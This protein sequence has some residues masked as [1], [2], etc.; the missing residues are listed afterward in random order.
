MYVPAASLGDG[1]YNGEGMTERGKSR[2]GVSLF[3]LPLIGYQR[4]LQLQLQWTVAI[5]SPF[6]SINTIFFSYNVILILARWGIKKEY[7]V[8]GWGRKGL[9]RVY[10]A[11]QGNK[12]WLA[13][14]ELPKQMRSVIPERHED[15]GVFL[16]KSENQLCNQSRQLLEKCKSIYRRRVARKEIWRERTE[17]EGSL[18]QQVFLLLVILSSID[19][20]HNI[21]TAAFP[22]FFRF[23]NISK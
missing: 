22:V 13:G 15:E 17:E 1:D 5:A 23:S 16:S 12:R 10:F 20:N 18:D 4:R 2:C 3:L 21:S 7:Q 6:M 11:S 8:P 19:T 9:K 14:A